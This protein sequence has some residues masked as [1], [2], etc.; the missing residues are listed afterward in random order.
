VEAYREATQATDH[1][2][3]GSPDLELG[4]AWVE[5]RA[6]VRATVGGVHPGVGTKNALISLGESTYLEIISPDPDQDTFSFPIDLPGL[7]EPRLVAWAVQVDDL[8]KLAYEAGSEEL[9][10][11][12]GARRTPEGESLSWKTMRI[13]NRFGSPEVEPFPFFIEW[14]GDSQYPAVSSPGGCR[15]LGIEITHEDPVGFENALADFGV[16]GKVREGAGRIVATI[17]TPRGTIEIE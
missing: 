3:L 15:L 4:I 17:E 7:S 2:L 8:K 13:K 5:D 9:D 10:F 14:G 1:L 16:G 11:R 12:D 6:G